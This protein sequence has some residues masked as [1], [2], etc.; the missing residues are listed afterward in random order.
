M[1][2]KIIVLLIS[3]IINFFIFSLIAENKKRR[4]ERNEKHRALRQRWEEVGSVVVLCE[5]DV[6]LRWRGHYFSNLSE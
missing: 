2:L 6:G 1:Y 4:L 3:K 5:C